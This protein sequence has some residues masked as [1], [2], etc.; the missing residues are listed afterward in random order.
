M[1]GNGAKVVQNRTVVVRY[2]PQVGL[3]LVRNNAKQS[4]ATTCD[5]QEGFVAI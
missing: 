4:H 1:P 2:A 5:P 3:N